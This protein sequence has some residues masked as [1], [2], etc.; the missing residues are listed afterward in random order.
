MPKGIST[1][2][3]KTNVFLL[4]TSVTYLPKNVEY[5]IEHGYGVCI[6][7]LDNHF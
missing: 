2:F 7:T 1:H 5:G 6:V 4:L 3:W